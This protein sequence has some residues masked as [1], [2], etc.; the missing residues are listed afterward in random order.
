MSEEKELLKKLRSDFFDI[1]SKKMRE[2]GFHRAT[3]GGVFYTS[4]SYG[5]KGVTLFLSNQW[6]AFRV[7]PNMFVCVDEI[8]RLL[9]KFRVEIRGDT[10][11]KTP[12]KATICKNL[13]NIKS[14]FY[15]WWN[16]YNDSDVVEC[17]DEIESMVATNGIPFL[18]KIDGLNLLLNDMLLS[19]D[20]IIA[21]FFAFQHEN[22]DSRDV[23]EQIEGV[24]KK[25]ELPRISHIDEFEEVLSDII[26]AAKKKPKVGGLEYQKL[27]ILSL[28]LSRKDILEKYLPVFETMLLESER[29]QYDEFL[30]F[31]PWI[32]E[33][34]EAR[35]AEFTLSNV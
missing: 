20:Q 22:G 1:F 33:K 21:D 27:L 9:W 3:R 2:H 12:N 26:A 11:L 14:G 23:E 32:V 17:A 16:N 6:G 31:K 25:H 4:T 35:N 18:D 29:I 19:T 8:E 13:G 30:L 10:D 15:R 5:S 24:H 34:F 7:E 28:I